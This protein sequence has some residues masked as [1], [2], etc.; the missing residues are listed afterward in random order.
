MRCP[1]ETLA[2][3]W[4]RGCCGAWEEGCRGHPAR[5]AGRRRQV[6]QA[7]TRT[8]GRARTDPS[9]GDLAGWPLRVFGWLRGVDGCA[10]RDTQRLHVQL[11]CL[12]ASRGKQGGGAANAQADQS[13]LALCG[14]ADHTGVWMGARGAGFAWREH[15]RRLAGGQTRLW[16]GVEIYAR[17][18]GADGRAWTGRCRRLYVRGT[19][20]GFKRSK[21]HQ[22]THTSLIQ[23]ENVNTKVRTA[24][25]TTHTG[26]SSC[27]RYHPTLT[28]CTRRPLGF[29]TGITDWAF[30]ALFLC[31]L[32]S[33]DS[34]SA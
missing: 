25:P 1:G 11:G 9:P 20:M 31:R 28:R 6:A 13:A 4:W 22:V 14:S 27:C 23:L 15:Q 16:C 33:S 34:L 7:V 3:R 5:W 8:G 18:Y 26:S 12:R 21:A 29:Q 10:L 32:T 30:G 24:A 19:V 2:F 17:A